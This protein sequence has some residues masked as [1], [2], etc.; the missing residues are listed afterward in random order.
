VKFLTVTDSDFLFLR[1]VRKLPVPVNFNSFAY[2]Q[3]KVVAGRGGHL[4]QALSAYEG[5]KIDDL[6]SLQSC[7][8]LLSK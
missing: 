6:T 3:L 1:V 7:G 8:T 5:F 2:K 4:C